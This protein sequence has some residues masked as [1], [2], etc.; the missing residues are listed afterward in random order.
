M[1]VDDGG[2]EECLARNGVHE[3]H[4][5]PWERNACQWVGLVFGRWNAGGVENIEEL[6]KLNSGEDSA[7]WNKFDSTLKHRFYI[8]VIFDG[9]FECSYLGYHVMSVLFGN[10]LNLIQ[11]FQHHISRHA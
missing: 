6:I 3:I 11:L 7:K 5:D 10:R 8:R 2:R 1:S 9:I 4:E